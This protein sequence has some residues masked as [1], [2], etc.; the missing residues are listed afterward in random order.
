MSEYSPRRSRSLI[1]FIKTGLFDSFAEA[2]ASVVAEAFLFVMGVAGLTIVYL[3]RA[4]MGAAC[5]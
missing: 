5:W 3:S 2:E 1:A 4:M